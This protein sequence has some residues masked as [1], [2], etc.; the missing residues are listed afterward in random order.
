MATLPPRKLRIA[1]PKDDE[2]A[3]PTCGQDMRLPPDAAEHLRTLEAE[4]AEAQETIRKALMEL[5]NGE[6]DA[7]Y[8]VLSQ[9]GGIAKPR[10]DKGEST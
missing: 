2:N 6:A 8:V 1:H 5:R 9:A 10:Q 7:A 4:L 3:C